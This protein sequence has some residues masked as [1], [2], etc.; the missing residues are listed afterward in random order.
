MNIAYNTDICKAIIKT[1]LH[2]M[3]YLPCYEVI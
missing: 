3:L 1:L 2:S